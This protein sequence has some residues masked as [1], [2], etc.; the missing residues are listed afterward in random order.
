[1]PAIFFFHKTWESTEYSVLALMGVR[2][3][4]KLTQ[5]S[6]A[7][8]TVPCLWITTLPSLSAFVRDKRNPSM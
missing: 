2:D 4:P 8:A 1:M 3:K 6:K 7:Y 5:K